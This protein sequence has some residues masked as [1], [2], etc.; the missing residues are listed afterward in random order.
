M[1]TLNTSK[2]ALYTCSFVHWD[3]DFKKGHLN[4][5]ILASAKYMYLQNNFPTQQVPKL[6]ILRGPYIEL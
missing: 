1:L 2:H 3:K 5:E 6:L 4:F